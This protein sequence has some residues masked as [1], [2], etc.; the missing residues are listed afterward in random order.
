MVGLM[1]Q[2]DADPAPQPAYQIHDRVVVV[3]DLPAGTDPMPVAA[4]AVSSLRDIN[5]R[6]ATLWPDGARTHVAIGESARR[7]LAVFDRSEGG[8]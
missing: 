5:L 1:I 8:L 3:L 4:W 6:D 2:L 7:V